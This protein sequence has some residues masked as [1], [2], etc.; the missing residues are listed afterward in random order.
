MNA[1][2][3]F[4]IGVGAFKDAF[5]FINKHKQWHYVIIPGIINAVVFYLFWRWLSAS[6][7]GWVD[8][9][10][11]PDCTDAE[12]VWAW[13]CPTV[14]FL[15]GALE[16]LVGMFI[17]IGMVG[18]YLSVYKNL[19]LIVFSPIIS[20]LIE[21]VDQKVNGVEEPFSL[22]QFLKDTVRGVVIAIRNLLLEGLCV[23]ALFIM[24]FIPVLNL[25]QPLLLFVV[26]AYFLGFGMMDYSLEIKRV[27]ARNSIGYIRANKSMAVGIGTV[28][29]LMFLIPFVGWM[30]APTFSAVAAYFAIQKLDE[31]TTT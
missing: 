19:I 24:G 11:T 1:F 25:V 30:L 7:S 26:G 29:Q 28:F 22:E 17:Y 3:K 12:G 6:V 13:F 31:K 16:W 4:G 15:S 10:I 9:V 14:S 18:I 27:N 2:Q 21:K 5:S 8:G 23:V 20:F